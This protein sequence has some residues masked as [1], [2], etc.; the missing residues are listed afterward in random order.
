MLSSLLFCYYLAMSPW[1]L[2][3]L[4]LPETTGDFWFV[5][6]PAVTLCL[7]K[8]QV[9]SLLL[10][11]QIWQISPR[12]KEAA[13]VTSLHGSPC[14]RI[15][16]PLVPVVPAIFWHLDSLEDIWS[17][18]HLFGFSQWECWP[19]AS[20]AMPYKEVEVTVVFLKSRWYKLTIF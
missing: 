6:L 12:R 3:F 14:S 18:P 1:S 19:A 17:L 8:V 4:S 20:L 2:W 10:W 9:H 5:C 13:Q 16:C 11:A 7:G 15:L